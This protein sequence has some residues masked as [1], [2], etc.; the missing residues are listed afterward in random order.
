MVARKK[1][2]WVRG[3]KRQKETHRG[4]NILFKGMPP[5]TYVL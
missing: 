3:R 1:E 4:Q 2:R 5:V